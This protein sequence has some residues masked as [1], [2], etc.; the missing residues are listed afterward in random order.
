MYASTSDVSALGRSILSSSLLPP[1]Q[2][3][4]WLKPAALTSEPVAGVGYPWGVRRIVLPEA[5]GKRTVDAYNKAGAVGY[6]SSLLNLLPDWDVGFSILI[7]GPATPGNM[8]FDLADVIGG[9]LLPALDAAARE[10][11]DATYSGFYYNVAANSTLRITTQSD[12]PGLGVE[13]WSS[14][15]TD[16]AYMAV[17]LQAEYTPFEPSVRLY[18]SGLEAATADGGKRVGFKAVFEDLQIP[19]R[20]NSMFSTDCGTW[21]GFTAVTY[22]SMPLDQFVFEFDAN[23]KV[24]NVEPIALRVKLQK[25]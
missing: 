5:N 1:A 2:T 21:V 23:G 19:A 17:A 25:A 12:R 7:A 15:G 18:P 22:G 8:N 13:Q 16:M 10:L 9:A 4:R 3:R 14:N 20:P 11:A 6:Y 24:V